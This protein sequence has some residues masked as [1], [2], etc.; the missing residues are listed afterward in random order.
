MQTKLK[1]RLFCANRN[2]FFIQSGKKCN[3]FTQYLVYM[4]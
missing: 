4:R 1:R 2:L 3:F